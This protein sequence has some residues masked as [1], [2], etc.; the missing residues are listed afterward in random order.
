M[1]HEKLKKIKI[2]IKNCYLSFS[3]QPEIG[4]LF[5]SISPILHFFY[6]LSK[7]FFMLMMQVIDSAALFLSSWKLIWN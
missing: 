6:I 5:Q 1:N 3:S 7:C 4:H 2:K